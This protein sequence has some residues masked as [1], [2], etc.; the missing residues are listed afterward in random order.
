V[1]PVLRVTTA[2]EQ[3]AGPACLRHIERTLVQRG[4]RDGG[5]KKVL[6][7]CDGFYALDRVSVYGGWCGRFG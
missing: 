3:K 2:T 7:I 6:L 1:V 5:M 4:V